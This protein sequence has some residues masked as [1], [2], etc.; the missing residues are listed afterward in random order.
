MA[1]QSSKSELPSYMDRSLAIARDLIRRELE[2]AIRKHLEATEPNYPGNGESNLD[3]Y[4]TALGLSGD[5][6]CQW[7]HN[8]QKK[9]DNCYWIRDWFDLEKFWEE[10]SDDDLKELTKGEVLTELIVRLHG[11]WFFVLDDSNHSFRYVPIQ[12]ESNEWG[13]TEETIDKP[14]SRYIHFGKGV[15]YSKKDEHQKDL[16]KILEHYLLRPGQGSVGLGLRAD[17]GVCLR[18]TVRDFRGAVALEDY[19]TRNLSYIGLQI[20]PKRKRIPKTSSGQDWELGR[21]GRPIGHWGVFFPAPLGWHRDLEENE[22]CD[23]CSSVCS[24]NASS[25]RDTKRGPFCLFKK[26][27]DVCEDYLQPLFANFYSHRS[28]RLFQSLVLRISGLGDDPQFQN[29]ELTNKAAEERRKRFF[30]KVL[31]CE[32]LGAVNESK[33]G[34]A[35]QSHSLVTPFQPRFPVVQVWECHH[36]IDFDRKGQQS[37]S[38]LQWRRSIGWSYDDLYFGILRERLGKLLGTL[39]KE[40]DEGKIDFKCFSLNGSD[41][42]KV[43]EFKILVSPAASVDTLTETKLSEYWCKAEKCIKEAVD[44]LEDTDSPSNFKEFQE[45]GGLEGQGN[46][47]DQIDRLL[48]QKV[49]AAKLRQLLRGHAAQCLASAILGLETK[50]SN[51]LFRTTDS[52]PDLKKRVRELNQTLEDLKE[53]QKA[54]KAIFSAVLQAEPF[55]CKVEGSNVPARV[56]IELKENRFTRRV[57]EALAEIM[58]ENPSK[59]G[60]FSVVTNHLSGDRDS[61]NKDCPIQ[62]DAKVADDRVGFDCGLETAIAVRSICNAWVSHEK[63]NDDAK[64]S[65]PLDAIDTSIVEDSGGLRHVEFKLSGGTRPKDNPITLT[66]E[67]AVPG[68]C[69]GWHVIAFEK[70]TES[71]SVSVGKLLKFSNGFHNSAFPEDS[72]KSLAKIKKVFEG[73]EAEYSKENLFHGCGI[74]LRGRGEKGTFLDYTLVNLL[75]PEKPERISKLKLKLPQIINSVWPDT[76]NPA[77]AFTKALWNVAIEGFEFPD[78]LGI[79]PDLNA[80]LFTPMF[81][82][83]RRFVGFSIFADSQDEKDVAKRVEFRPAQAALVEFSTDYF[84]SA[85]SKELGGLEIQK[86]S[87]GIGESIGEST[88]FHDYSKDLNLLDYQLREYTD[89]VVEVKAEVEKLTDELVTLLSGLDAGEAKGSVER[90]RSEIERLGKPSYDYMLRLRFMMAHLKTETEGRL[91][92]QPEWCVRWVKDGTRKD[93]YLLIRALVWMPVGWKYYD[94]LAKELRSPDG[95]GRNLENLDEADVYAWSRMMTYETAGLKDRSDRD[96]FDGDQERL[97]RTMWRLFALERIEQSRFATF[98]PA[99]T[100]NPGM[101]LDAKLLWRELD[102]REDELYLPERGLLPLLVFSLRTAFQ[103]S[104]LRTAYDTA[105]QLG[106]GFTEGDLNVFQ[107]KSQRIQLTTESDRLNREANSCYRIHLNFPLPRALS[108]DEA[109]SWEESLIYREWISQ[110]AHY[111]RLTYPWEP[112]FTLVQAEGKRYCRIILKA[113]L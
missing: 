53:A 23:N 55:Q 41:S 35:G 51:R 18:D 48:D 59:L 107:G 27:R 9:V 26:L 111:E 33:V 46:Q 30:Q 76:D 81:V 14:I 71:D 34:G 50:L 88:T 97:A 100:L 60:R 54:R 84:E 5:M 44:Q 89:E 1:S 110:T 13:E 40:K 102:D 52:P 2:D 25:S 112:E 42:E 20:F 67:R 21:R 103:C 10:F 92:E 63:G 17:R 22:L 85:I 37:Q 66:L 79:S 82:D 8:E 99:P 15:Y 47:Q 101:S 24:G 32:D 96:L 77:Q 36:A 12:S 39:E 91:Y 72:L 80:H 64:Q 78:T 69:E 31:D 68:E 7:T 6:K 43:G 28:S 106:E 75:Y 38:S 87:I 94:N 45:F 62:S 90:I 19:L 74:L 16:S 108:D 83:G 95:G 58:L 105:G 104:W 3:H 98:F 73:E 11:F 65:E 57:F 56:E 29:S 93:L 70:N 4:V 49:R 61:A 86:A 113:E 109:E